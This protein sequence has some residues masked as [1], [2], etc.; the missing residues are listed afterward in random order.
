MQGSASKT[1]NGSRKPFGKHLKRGLASPLV[2]FVRCFSFM[3][4]FAGAQGGCII[5][6]A[7]MYR[8]DP[9]CNHQR[10]FR[11][12]TSDNMER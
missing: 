7:W 5:F 6:F 3:S 10:K 12:Q 9:K 1:A 4:V 8:I 11:S 2:D